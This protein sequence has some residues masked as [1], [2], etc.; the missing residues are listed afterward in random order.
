[1]N[2]FAFSVGAALYVAA[3]FLF[4][5]LTERIED[6]ER[7]G[8][9]HYLNSDIQYVPSLI[10]DLR[11]GTSLDGW[12]LPPANYFFPDALLFAGLLRFSPA[13]LAAQICGL[14]LFTLNTIS[15]ILYLRHIRGTALDAPY[16]LL[17][18]SILLLALPLGILPGTFFSLA[19]PTFHTSA[20]SGLFLFLL[21]LAN[22]R[23]QRAVQYLMLALVVLLWG[24]SDA[25]FLG[26]AGSA[27]AAHILLQARTGFTRAHVLLPVVF[28]AASIAGRKAL[29]LLPM[30]AVRVSPEA[31]ILLFLK[32][33]FPGP[34]L[35]LDLK[36]P[37]YLTAFLAGAWLL[38]RGF[39]SRQGSAR[40]YALAGA[41]A[42]GCIL[43]ASFFSR[44]MGLPGIVDRYAAF[45]VFFLILPVTLAA[46]MPVARLTLFAAAALSAAAS[47][48]SLEQPVQKSVILERAACLDEL[49]ANYGFSNGLS[50]Y[51]NAK[52]LTMAARRLQINQV[53]PDLG[54]RLWVSNVNWYRKPDGSIRRYSIILPSGLSEEDILSRFGPPRM[55][56]ACAGLAVWIYGTNGNEPLQ[57]FSAE[58]L[59]AW[60][61][62]RRQ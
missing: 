25:L 31:D 32:S 21:V 20:T 27:L 36:Q 3:L 58:E 49:A 61:S 54:P 51:W 41:A 15:L 7:S 17:G 48:L 26:L 13:I 28:L 1:M 57:P 6:Q 10:R 59:S 62:S 2:R 12:S 52:S 43:S 22:T 19:L 37:W 38:L 34:E 23:I 44:K 39:T 11:S 56:H 14:L 24:A 42:L 4:V 40:W 35:W 18:A 50:D 55:V 8:L 29:V 45:S 46:R 60:Q 16:V 53:E 5:P 47:V 30:H 9:A 33:T